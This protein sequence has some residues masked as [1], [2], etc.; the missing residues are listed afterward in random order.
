MEY[1]YDHF[2]PACNVVNND[3]KPWTVTPEYNLHNILHWRQRLAKLYRVGSNYCP[4]YQL[5][6]MN[7][8]DRC[9]IVQSL[10]DWEGM[11][12]NGT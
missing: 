6:I 1:N 11:Q 4:K 7:K 8:Y 9:G 3:T 10:Q 5:N 12:R 2:V